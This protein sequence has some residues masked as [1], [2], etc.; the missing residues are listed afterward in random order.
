MSKPKKKA[1]PVS[2]QQITVVIGE[3][4]PCSDLN[5]RLRQIYNL[6][7]AHSEQKVDTGAKKPPVD[8]QQN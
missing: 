5:R 7:L 6:A 3:S 8:D 4:I 1:A 2:T